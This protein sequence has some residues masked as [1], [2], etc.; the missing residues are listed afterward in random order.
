M[1]S[2]S[3][4]PLALL[5][6]ILATLPV[7]HITAFRLAC[8]WSCCVVD[9]DSL[10][11]QLIKDS[12]GVPACL[13][14]VW[15]CENHR[16]LFQLL[17]HKFGGLLR[18]PLYLALHA[19]FG[20]LLVA[21]A[22]PPAI[23]LYSLIPYRLNLPPALN[24]VY[25]IYPTTFPPP[26]SPPPSPQ[27]SGSD[28][29]EIMTQQLSV[30][31]ELERRPMHPSVTCQQ[32]SPGASGKVHDAAFAWQPLPKPRKAA[33][34][35][36]WWA[37][38][39]HAGMDN[40]L[41]PGAPLAVFCCYEARSCRHV[42][43]DPLKR[44]IAHPDPQRSRQTPQLLLPD[45]SNE[46]AQLQNQF[47]LL[48]HVT[49]LFSNGHDHPDFPG[50]AQALQAAP[51]PS[52]EPDMWG[53][54][55]SRYQLTRLPPDW[56]ERALLYAPLQ[57]KLWVQSGSSDV[58]GAVAAGADNAAAL[59]AAVAGGPA[60]A[61]AAAAAAGPGPGTGA[62][63][64]AGSASIGEGAGAAVGLSDAGT[65][66]NGGTGSTT[67][68][69][70]TVGAPGTG[71][72]VGLGTA[73]AP[74]TGGADSTIGSAGTIGTP[75]TGCAG[76]TTCTAGTTD[77]AGG[78]TVRGAE[79]G[80]GHDRAHANAGPAEAGGSGTNGPNGAATSS[81]EE[82][83]APASGAYARGNTVL[84]VQA[85]L[86]AAPTAAGEEEEEE[87]GS[88]EEEDMGE[89]HGS[90]GSAQRDLETLSE[91]IS[92]H[93]PCTSTILRGIK[94]LGDTNVPAGHVSFEVAVED[95]VEG[96]GTGTSSSAM[97]GGVRWEVGQPFRMPSGYRSIVE[98]AP[99]DP[100][101][102]QPADSPRVGQLVIRSIY[103]GLGQIAG[104]GYKQPK[105]S[106]LDLLEL[107]LQDPQGII[108]TIPSAAFGLC[109]HELSSF[110]LFSKMQLP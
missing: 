20:G 60:A 27:P 73:S 31:R 80:A 100:F 5:H 62:G 4:L 63:V 23:K 12:H 44:W 6:N 9:D 18:A 17:I 84:G 102:Q 39:I 67:G 107:D 101:S 68:T 81:S 19:P 30:R 105:W 95:G 85:E 38:W 56:Q 97:H 54:V 21:R 88:G 74:S 10:W 36:P 76:S 72:A 50:L 78:G 2:I 22:E 35:A 87:E 93:G 11:K 69:A 82:P 16:E 61:A 65:P 8:R 57:A 55:P 42:D 66:G 53:R 92:A 46:M 108:A 79:G 45:I 32:T 51:P 24:H 110:S 99:S 103:K 59:A 106:G 40:S 109:W 43:E 91:A 3:D 96:Q 64:P 13:P 14:E 58:L 75:G 48:N 15:H 86:C 52:P 70:G 29:G 25:T 26:P 77:Q 47:F 49:Y 104:T 89:G 94:L 41:G 34:R 1:T 33:K 98:L 28:L 90:S 83:V 71:V 37:W 7:K